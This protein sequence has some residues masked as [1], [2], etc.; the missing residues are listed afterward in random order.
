MSWRDEPRSVDDRYQVS[1]RDRDG[2][3]RR[4]GPH[5]GRIRL[6]P[7]RV[8][9]A[10]ALVGSIGFLLYAVT[11]R[12]PSQIP[13]L[14]SGAA[15]L[16]LVFSALAVAGVI[17]N[18]RSARE[19]FGGRSFA[20]ALLGGVAAVIAFACFSGAVILALVAKP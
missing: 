5:L 14:A 8:T 18:Y 11:V 2:T 9:L 17:S 15:V 19:G 12:D 20:M 13:L 6:T 16:G 1:P 3:R 7:T 10:V 4:V